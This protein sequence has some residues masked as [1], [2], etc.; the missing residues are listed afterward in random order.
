MDER[1][2]D[3]TVDIILS[4]RAPVPQTEKSGWNLLNLVLYIVQTRSQG[5]LG[6]DTKTFMLENIVQTVCDYHPK[7]SLAECSAFFF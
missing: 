1:D 3:E 4:I 5:P 2:L 7:A 6:F